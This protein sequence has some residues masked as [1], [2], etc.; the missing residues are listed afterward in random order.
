MIQS[1][2]H[3]FNIVSTN[4]SHVLG[5]YEKSIS[6]TIYIASSIWGVRGIGSCPNMMFDSP[7]KNSQLAKYFF[8]NCNTTHDILRNIAGP[9]WPTLYLVPQLAT[10]GGAMAPHL[11][12]N[13]HTNKSTRRQESESAASS[14]NL[15][16][17]EQDDHLIKQT[18]DLLKWENNLLK[19]EINL[20]KSKIVLLKFK[21]DLVKCSAMQNMQCFYTSGLREAF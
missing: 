10:K 3:I 20:L 17:W 9:F 12:V 21:I 8:W 2:Y 1:I 6:Y 11:I 18:D 7:T 16:P 13:I 19:R 14:P 15:E 5:T 4:T